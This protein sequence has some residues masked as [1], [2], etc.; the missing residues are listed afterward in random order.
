MPDSWKYILDSDQYKGRIAL[1]SESADLTRLAAKYLGHSVNG[2]QPDMV[3]QIEKMLIKQKPYA[4][5][6]NVGQGKRL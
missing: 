3:A 1:L 5:S 2:I 6:E 4:F